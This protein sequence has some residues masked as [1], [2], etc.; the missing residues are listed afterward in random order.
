MPMS[1]MLLKPFFSGGIKRKELIELFARRKTDEGSVK[2]VIGHPD[3]LGSAVLRESG[4]EVQKSR[5]LAFLKKGG[6]IIAG[7]ASAILFALEADLR[8]IV[9]EKDN[10]GFLITMLK[11]RG[12]I[13][14]DDP[15]FFGEDLI[16]GLQHFLIA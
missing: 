5:I 13:A 11:G 14:I 4:D 9:E 8:R 12:V 16:Q 7:G 3:D 10:I 6:E 2:I 1:S 15:A